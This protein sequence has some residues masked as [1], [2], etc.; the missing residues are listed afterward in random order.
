MKSKSL[1]KQYCSDNIKKIAGLVLFGLISILFLIGI[2][3]LIKFVVDQFSLV[4][5]SRIEL[6]QLKEFLKLISDQSQI[7]S[8]NAEIETLNN[9]I[10]SSMVTAIVL[11]ASSA[12]V[13]ILSFYTN[14]VFNRRLIKFGSDITNQLRENAFSTLM[15]GEL[16]EIR[17]L[18]IEDLKSNVLDSTSKIGND[19][20]SNHVAKVFYYILLFVSALIAL[21][22]LDT[23]CGFVALGISPIYYIVHKYMRKIALKKETNYIKL[24]RE[25]EEYIKTN[26]SN[27]K[28]IKVR[29]A[30]ETEEST[31]KEMLSKAKKSYDANHTFL[32]L[33]SSLIVSLVINIVVCCAVGIFMWELSKS[34]DFSFGNLVACL[35]LCPITFNSFKSLADCYSDK[36]DINSTFNSLNQILDLRAESRSE[37]ISSLEEIH[38]LTFNNVSFDYANMIQKG[39]EK[40]NF[41]VKK[42]EKIGILGYQKSGKTTIADLI[43][44]IIR[45]RFGNV[46]INNC[47]INKIST[48]YLREIIAYVPQ[49]YSLF[50]GSIEKNII[51]PSDLD[52]YRYNDALNK[53][54]LKTLL[55][56][57]PNRDQENVFN[58]KL[59]P[60]DIER[61]GLAHALYKDVPIIVLDEAT[62]KLDPQTE[63]EIMNE[64]YK[65]KN[66][67]TVVISNRISTLIKCDKILILNDGKVVEYG[68]TED[69]LKDTR[70]TYSKMIGDINRK[71]V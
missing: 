59:S 50:D 62:N 40:I 30:I 1:V 67:I 49:N 32:S 66:K 9:T 20:Y 60:A 26:V 64:F 46:L 52:E 68:K 38:S 28:S 65:L 5:S 56:N 71:I 23:I 44:K 36:H 37:T 29:N 13:A 24:N 14:L 2:P 63:S 21:F 33:N 55:M 11:T 41:E 3:V 48:K 18:S 12:V 54:K 17:D 22:C 15:R 34:S 35:V 43:C 61:I 70:S 25:Q 57:L 53:C 27:L 10:N 39:V 45:P 7:A 51:Y 31:Y 4:I 8:I 47:D 58:V 16:Y 69:L 19:Y 42:G 6:N